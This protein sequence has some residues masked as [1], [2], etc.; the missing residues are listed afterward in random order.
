MFIINYYKF[1]LFL[2]EFN[3]IESTIDLPNIWENILD[4]H[5]RLITTILKE[6]N[7]WSES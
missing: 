5:K 1:I 2:D 3:S 4:L 6:R 7:Y